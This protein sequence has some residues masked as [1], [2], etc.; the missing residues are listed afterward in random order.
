MRRFI[1]RFWIVLSLC[2]AAIGPAAATC[3]SYIPNQ[4]AKPTYTVQSFWTSSDGS[5]N[6]TSYTQ[7]VR[8]P[9][10]LALLSGLPVPGVFQ[11]CNGAFPTVSTP[12]D[13]SEYIS[14][15][16]APTASNSYRTSWWTASAVNGVITV[17]RNSTTIQSPE[18]VYSDSQPQTIIYTV[19]T[20]ALT[21]QEGGKT[22]VAYTKG[23]SGYADRSA[24]YTG[25]WPIT[26]STPPSAPTI[27]TA[28]LTGAGTAS[29]SFSAASNTGGRDIVSYTVTSIP[30]GITATGTGSPIAVSGLSNGFAY[31]FIVTATN[32]IAGDIGGTGA[33]STPSNV[34]STGGV[35]TVVATT[36][37]PTLAEM[38][39][40][41][42]WNM[43]GVSSSTPVKV[44]ETFSDATKVATVWKWVESSA[45]WAFYSPL[46]P[47]G[48]AEYAV[49]KGYDFLTSIATGEGFWVNAK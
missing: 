15:V 20:G 31:T 43:R 32:T 18:L 25:K 45:K 36:T 40:T 7:D 49:S 38:H 34:V 47:D 11:E 46:L 24:S 23:G 14:R 8:N 27:G 39:L 5:Q 37:P 19:K 2:S 16:E 22:S 21:L 3:T 35:S 1:G 10:D 9:L 48:G 26:V 13:G 30:V 44:A 41:S 42:G 17:T 28:T 4:I 33:A 12:V 29:I 6:T